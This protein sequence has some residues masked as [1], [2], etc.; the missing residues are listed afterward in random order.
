[1]RLVAALV[2]GTEEVLQKYYFFFQSLFIL[3]ERE[4]T[5]V[6]EG[7]AERERERERESQAGSVWLA[8]QPDTGLELGNL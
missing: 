7:R 4:S 6:G 2:D 3:R 1:M 8:T 5:H